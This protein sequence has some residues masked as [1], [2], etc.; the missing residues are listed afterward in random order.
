MNVQIRI[1]SIAVVFAISGCASTGTV[2]QSSTALTPADTNVTN[3]RNEPGCP[4]DT[5][6]TPLERDLTVPFNQRIYLLPSGRLCTPQPDSTPRV[7]QV[8]APS[9]SVEPIRQVPFFRDGFHDRH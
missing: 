2:S 7:G 4:P 9:P 8:L 1:L 6:G 5:D 3:S